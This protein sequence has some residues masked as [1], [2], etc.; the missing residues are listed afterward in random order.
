MPEKQDLET[1]HLRGDQLTKQIVVGT[2][3][4]IAI[5]FAATVCFLALRELTIPDA[6]DRLLNLVLGGVGAL[7]AKTSVERAIASGRPGGPVSV[8]Q[9]APVE[10]VNAPGDVIETKPSLIIPT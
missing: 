6:L 5:A 2:L 1:C 4:G 3:C 10:M 9:T 7:L 8:A